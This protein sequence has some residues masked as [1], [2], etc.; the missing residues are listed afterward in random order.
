MGR[1][2][3]AALTNCFCTSIATIFACMQWKCVL[4][5]I[6]PLKQEHA[7]RL[8]Q[9][10]KDCFCTSIATIFA[11]SWIEIKPRGKDIAQLRR[12]KPWSTDRQI[13]SGADRA[14]GGRPVLQWEPTKYL[15]VLLAS[16]IQISIHTLMLYHAIMFIC[17]LVLTILTRTSKG[18]HFWKKVILVSKAENPP[19]LS[20]KWCV[21]SLR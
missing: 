16:T 19:Y 12:G 7:E 17:S 11:C 13:V 8:C 1:L 10:T 6:K 15:F 5:A 14:C 18:L 20:F 4:K 3:P 2:E 21:L 9:T